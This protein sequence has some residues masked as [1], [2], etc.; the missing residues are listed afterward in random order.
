MGFLPQV[1]HNLPPTPALCAPDVNAGPNLRHVADTRL[2]S[3]LCP[4]THFQNGNSERIHYIERNSK[5]NQ[6]SF[7][8]ELSNWGAKDF[9]KIATGEKPCPLS[10]TDWIICVQT[11]WYRIGNRNVSPNVLIKFSMG[12]GGNYSDFWRRYCISFVLLQFLGKICQKRP[13][14]I[15][16]FWRGNI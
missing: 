3:A 11:P 1:V 12:R 14:L 10:L 6:T 16:S 7:K 8:I 9:F 4:K 5:C 2:S 15:I 13:D